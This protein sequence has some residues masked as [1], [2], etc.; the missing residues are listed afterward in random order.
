M[1][2][3]LIG[4]GNVAT[5]L[6]KALKGHGH[7]ICQVY[8][9]TAHS[10]GFLGD[11]LDAEPV[12]NSEAIVDGADLYL[13]ALKDDA[14]ETVLK[15]LTLINPLMVHTS[16]S[17]PLA[18]LSAVSNRY[19]VLYPLQT[20]SKNRFVDLSFVP[21]FVEASDKSTRELLINLA[22]HMSRSVHLLPSDDRAELHLAAVFACNFVNHLYDVA[23]DL[24]QRRNLPFEYLLPLIDETASKVHDFKPAEAQ[25]GPAVRYD[26]HIIGKHLERLGE[27]QALASVYRCL[28]DSIFNRIKH[29]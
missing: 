8:S 28:S 4:A 16:G 15:S 7:E 3:T 11:M 13:C 25:T 26:K 29:T 20:F 22:S 2:I 23:H 6:G 10:A 27:D 17:L 24:L 19:G 5:H 18:V 14:V 21:F 12:T 9:R 1:L